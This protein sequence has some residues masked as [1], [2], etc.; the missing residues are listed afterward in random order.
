MRGIFLRLFKPRWQHSSASVRYQAIARLSAERAD[1]R[2]ALEHLVQDV[3][4]EVRLAALARLEDIDCLL[5]LRTAGSSR[6]LD[7]R[8]VWLLSGHAG[9]P[10]L[11]QR[12]GYLTQLGDG[13][14]FE[15][16]AMEADNQQL[17][18]EALAQLEDEE[19]LIR[20]ACDN[21]IAAI[22]QAAAARVDSDEGLSHLAREAR[23][24]GQVMR[25]ARQRL[26]QR[27]ADADQQA[28]ANS[29]RDQLLEQIEHL[30]G[31]S[32][33]SHDKARFEYFEKSFRELGPA[34]AEQERRFREAHQHYRKV[35]SDQ[36]HHDRAQEDAR[37]RR[38]AA[39]QE[40]EAQL[41][42]ME[43]GLNG[44]TKGEGLSDQEIAL[45]RSQRQLL[46]KHWLALSEQH[47]PDEVLRRR[48]ASILERYENVLAARGRL[49]A[50]TESI[51]QAL[52]DNDDQQLA[53]L[54]AACRW[55]QELPLAPLLR[56]AKE[57]LQENKA[58]TVQVQSVSLA[59][60]SAGLDRLQQQLDKG[61]VRNASGLY[62][63]IAQQAEALDPA[64]AEG[65]LARF[66][67]L[68]ARLAE[69]RDWRAFVAGPKRQ[70]LCESIDALAEQTQLNDSDLNHRHRQL[71]QEWKS[72]G[73]AAG[74]S[75]LSARFRTASDNIRQ[76]LQPWRERQAQEREHN[77]AARIELC[78]QLEALLEQ[79]C[80]QADPDALR[81]IR[82][83][84]RQL[85]QRHSPVPSKQAHGVERRFSHARHALQALI[86]RR[87]SEIAAA[88]RAL[89][90]QLRALRDRDMDAHQRA[91]QAKAMQ[92][93]WR[94][95]G[96]AP[97]GEEQALWR[98]FRHLC[99]EIFSRRDAARKDRQNHLQQ[100]LDDMQVLID[101]L[102]TWRPVSVS[103]SAALDSAVEQAAALEPL[104]HG[105]RSE[106]MSR[107]WAGIV[108]ARRI[109]LERLAL[110]EE[111]KY[112]QQLGPLIDS[113]LAADDMLLE[114]G[115]VVA[116][117]IESA[118]QNQPLS[119]DVHQAHE[120]RNAARL[121]PDSPAQVEQRL[122]MLRVHLAVL[123]HGR[124]PPGDEPYR[125]AVQV[126]RLNQGIGQA[127]KPHRSD[128][129]LRRLLLELLATGP[130]SADLWAREAGA[131]GEC[132]AYLARQMND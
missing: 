17:R 10:S 46:V 33:E 3:D 32:W 100:R 117:G 36:Q 131:L 52:S 5:R 78:E 73:D 60:F 119:A 112:W 71:V 130:I 127:T 18:M 75:D 95:L 80:E 24:D 15:R 104:P 122:A 89:I 105:R 83:S 103:D 35:L 90:E 98:D 110:A 19:A 59:A 34:S 49:D 86:E 51:I 23:R 81:R 2:Q 39:S 113:H 53:A 84:S 9:A 125:L 1:H 45:L 42:A 76:R 12:I 68:G 123:S 128:Q 74:D 111:A 99:D 29:R 79:P 82:D 22:R 43:E 87:A 77:L 55:P 69:L 70:Q 94:Q 129:E 38:A 88:K 63:R 14:L 101:Q 102:D 115:G 116:V 61:Q 62:Q 6:E 91:E 28:K 26:A 106:G 109:N 30:V 16:I 50:N 67:R 92:Q 107:R 4:A 57:Q 21:K 97:K 37:Q 124:V 58:E 85:W 31:S 40:R 44:L 64:A 54:V 11:S 41:A 13:V 72:L 20:L 132:I 126:E 65:A 120:R 118:G 66:R 93:Q 56:H 108:Q 96:R 121:V 7:D 25:Q 114:G 47:S 27:R 8:L 48:Y